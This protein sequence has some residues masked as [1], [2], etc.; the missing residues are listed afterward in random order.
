MFSVYR[1]YQK[2]ILQ[3]F[4]VLSIHSTPLSAILHSQFQLTAVNNRNTYFIKLKITM[5]SK[6]NMCDTGNF[7]VKEMQQ[8]DVCEVEYKFFSGMSIYITLCIILSHVLTP[9]ST[10]RSPNS[11]FGSTLHLPWSCEVEYKFYSGMHW[12][13]THTILVH[14]SVCFD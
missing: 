12:R 14:Q 13:P 3:G 2:E 5:V 8:R 7:Y 9:G 10:L 4:S 6:C 1:E 11:L